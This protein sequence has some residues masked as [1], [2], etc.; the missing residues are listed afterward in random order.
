MIP[1]FAFCAFLR[2][3]AA[4]RWR[5]EIIEGA[6]VAKRDR[7]IAR[8]LR[9]GGVWS[10][11]VPLINLRRF[12]PS[13]HGRPAALAVGRRQTERLNNVKTAL[14]GANEAVLIPIAG[15]AGNNRRVRP[16]LHRFAYMGQSPIPRSRTGERKIRAGCLA[17]RRKAEEVAAAV[18]R[19]RGVPA[20]DTNPL[21]QQHNLNL[22][23]RRQ[24]R[25]RDVEN[26]SLGQI[27]R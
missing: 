20:A 24:P 2:N 11:C 16:A 19:G 18:Q 6:A 12:A 9:C 22:T 21:R 26:E 7:R 15:F 4:Q 23:V 17:G 10:V 8:F 25:E 3:P 14:H 5:Q 13:T 27:N 1:G